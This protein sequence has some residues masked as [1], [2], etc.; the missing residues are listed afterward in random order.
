MYAYI[1]NILYNI[2]KNIYMF[3]YMG[4]YIP[5]SLCRTPETN[6]ML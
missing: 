3:R 4:V 2:Y 6:T 1:H 5:E